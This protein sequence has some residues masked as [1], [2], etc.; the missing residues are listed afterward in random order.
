[1]DAEK[2]E[3]QVKDGHIMDTEA[4]AEMFYIVNQLDE[5]GGDNDKFFGFQQNIKPTNKNRLSAQFATE[6]ETRYKD[7]ISEDKMKE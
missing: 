1:L 7:Y 5:R 3:H 6:L 4:K 2:G